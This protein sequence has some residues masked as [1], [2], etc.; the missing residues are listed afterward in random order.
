MKQRYFWVAEITLPGSSYKS[1]FSYKRSMISVSTLS[2]E[3]VMQAVT[4]CLLEEALTVRAV[5]KSQI[6]VL[7]LE[8]KVVPFQSGNEGE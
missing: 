2:P 8:F 4:D 3:E 7:F 6:K 1:S 5:E